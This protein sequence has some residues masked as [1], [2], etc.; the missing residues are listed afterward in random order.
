MRYKEYIDL[1]TEPSFFKIDG[2]NSS[3]LLNDECLLVELP[4]TN[5]PKD[6]ISK[7]CLDIKFDNNFSNVT[8][9]FI[10]IKEIENLEYESIMNQIHNESDNIYLGNYNRNML[11]NIYNNLEFDLE[12]IDINFSS[13]D[14]IYVV[15]CIQT[16]DSN[17][18]CNVNISKVNAYYEITEIIKKAEIVNFDET[19]LIGINI[20][21]G[22]IEMLDNIYTYKDGLYELPYIIGR[23]KLSS[24]LYSNQSLP[25]NISTIFDYVHM[26]YPNI[27]IK[28]EDDCFF[29][30]DYT[31]HPKK[32]KKVSGEFLS[33]IEIEKVKEKLEEMYTECI[34][35]MLLEKGYYPNNV[36][37]FEFETT[38]IVFA[39]AEE[40]NTYIQEVTFK[41]THILLSEEIEEGFAIMIDE[42]KNVYIFTKEF[43]GGIYNEY[44]LYLDKI[45]NQH[46]N[47]LTFVRDSTTKKI[48][49]IKEIDVWIKYVQN[50]IDPL[51]ILKQVWCVDFKKETR[52]IE[53]DDYNIYEGQYVPY[54]FKYKL[55]DYSSSLE[56]ILKEFEITFSKGPEFLWTIESCTDLITKEHYEFLKSN[57]QTTINKYLLENIESNPSK[58]LLSS[59]TFTCN[60]GYNILRNNKT[61]EETIYLLDKRKNLVEIIEDNK[62][63]ISNIY[64]ESLMHKKCS[65]KCLTYDELKNNTF[66]EDLKGWTHSKATVVYK[67]GFYG[68]HHIHL[69]QN[70]TLSQTLNLEGANSYKI[71][72]RIKT[73]NNTPCNIVVE[74]LYYVSNSQSGSIGGPSLDTTLEAVPLEFVYTSDSSNNDWHEFTS[75][76]F[77]I[78]QKATDINA[79][80]TVY[81]DGDVY[82]DN[83]EVIKV[84]TNKNILFNS[85]FDDLTMWQTNEE[86]I[87]VLPNALAPEYVY[88]EQAGSIS[89]NLTPTAGD[90]YY[91]RGLVK[92]ESPSQYPVSNAS[93]TL[94]CYCLNESTLAL[95]PLEI[96]KEVSFDY[97]V[98]GW[99]EFACD[100]LEILDTYLNPSL[101][102]K[103]NAS[104]P[105][106]LKELYITNE[107]KIP[108]NLIVNSNFEDGI[109]SYTTIESLVDQMFVV[110]DDTNF[111][112]ETD[113]SISKSKVYGKNVLKITGNK[114]NSP[115]TKT[116]KR[117]IKLLKLMG[118]KKQNTVIFKEFCLLLISLH[119]TLCF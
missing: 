33:K 83:L 106:Y 117:K 111:I 23:S 95:D 65:K 47:E 40:S 92:H 76:S 71:K 102:I 61:A 79:N 82:I 10:Q 4:T 48:T 50:D 105:L 12:N 68:K 9:K 85:T 66:K 37:E 69:K 96:K 39:K 6:R 51:N 36:E 103:V 52:K 86:T 72:G 3:I 35:I 1:N 28:D 18:P 24:N 34:K 63:Q 14:N 81:A 53:L 32:F 90:K 100:E 8:F 42:S 112:L 101:T 27:V 21:T 91:F 57:N 55:I 5:F 84:S 64:D 94:N 2:T 107:N 41:G 108:S 60:E 70:Q 26:N 119:Q 43:I 113:E 67:E 45:I 115:S 97:N 116:L 16:N 118:L 19:R 87:E 74:G 54:T 88:L 62:L 114:L 17:E 77:Y 104:E 109:V 98:D 99:Y 58:I 110:S 44:I 29:I 30:N 7:L 80:I 11:S 15:V 78:L 93:I 56:E 31:G 22:D 25:F 46:N 75:S 38:E 20:K 73:T 89:R 49:N 13:N 59:I